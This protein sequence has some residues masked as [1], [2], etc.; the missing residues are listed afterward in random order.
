MHYDKSL[1]KLYQTL[2]PALLVAFFFARNIH[3]LMREKCYQSLHGKA[4]C[5]LRCMMR[6]HHEGAIAEGAVECRINV[7]KC[8]LVRY[9]FW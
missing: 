1:R 9:M 8:S 3:F 2:K 5:N 6:Q 4:L 7:R